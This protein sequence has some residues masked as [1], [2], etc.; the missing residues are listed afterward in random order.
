MDI[1]RA[2]IYAILRGKAVYITFALV[3]IFNILLVAGRVDVG[4][5]VGNVEAV[6]EQVFDGASSAGILA[7][8]AENLIFFLLPLILA[9]AVPIFNHGTVKN[10]LAWGIS[11]TKL[12]MS[13]LALAIG[14]SVI[15]L[16]FYMITGMIIVTAITGF[17][18]PVPDG[19]WLNLLK[20]FF[21]QLFMLISLACI[22]VFLVFTT[23]RTA[24]VNAVYIVLMLV[25]NL[26]IFILVGSGFNVERLFEIT[27]MAGITMLAFI[28]EL[29][30][31]TIFTILGACAVYILVS[32]GFNVQR[33]FEITSMAGITMLAFIDELEVSTIFTILGACAV[34]ILVTTIGGIL[35]FRRAEI[36]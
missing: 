5:A 13:K 4:I 21:A 33:L 27:S 9:A 14:F 28:D 2:D 18:G 35:L 24:I 20:I 8:Q 12:Y 19:Y 6:G 10:D 36:K 16:L 7:S 15:L 1:I 34:Y 26:I 11:R 31:S 29:E 32:S 17:G 3:L 25:P 30:V 22:G 23:K